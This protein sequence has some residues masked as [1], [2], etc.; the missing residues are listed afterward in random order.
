MRQAGG[1][2]GGAGV[3]AKLAQLRETAK[4]AAADLAVRDGQARQMLQRGEA[5]DAGVADVAAS[6]RIQPGQG[7]ER[8]KQRH[9]CI[10]E[11]Q[12]TTR[13]SN[14]RRWVVPA[15]STASLT[16]SQQL[17]SSLHSAVNALRRASQT[18]MSQTSAQP[19]RQSSSSAI[20][21]PMHHSTCTYTPPHPETP[22]R[23]RAVSRLRA[24]RLPEVRGGR[25]QAVRETQLAQRG[26]NCDV[27]KVGAGDRATACELEPRQL[28]QAAHVAHASKRWPPR[29][30]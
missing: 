5:R 15:S 16:R 12:Q 25:S 14:R 17:T 11:T 1:A 28:T 13:F 27:Q 9:A 8:A 29:C 26:A 21:P 6:A 24:A 10:G 18:V 2:D 3:G 23:L 22:S 20:R 7:G 30:A 19:S 4:A